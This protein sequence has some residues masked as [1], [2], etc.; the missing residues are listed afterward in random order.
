MGAALV[1][2]AAYSLTCISVE[3]L[4]YRPFDYQD[5]L[6]NISQ[7]GLVLSETFQNFGE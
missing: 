7:K 2:A 3:L 4:I 1:I 5:V 6:L